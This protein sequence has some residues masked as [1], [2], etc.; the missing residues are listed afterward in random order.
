MPNNSKLAT[1]DNLLI[2]FKKL[3]NDDSRSNNLL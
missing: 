2:S 3:F 1:Y